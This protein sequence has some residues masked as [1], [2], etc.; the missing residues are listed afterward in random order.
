MLPL[1]ARWIIESPMFHVTLPA[2]HHRAADARL[3]AFSI[4]SRIA[5][6]KVQVHIGHDQV[7]SDAV[8]AQLSIGLFKRKRV[9]RR[10]FLAVEKPFVH[11]PEMRGF[12]V[13]PEVI[14]QASD[15]RQLLRRADWTTDPYWVINRRL[16]PGGDIFKGFGQVKLFEGVVHHDFEAW[17]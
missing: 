4:S 13:Q 2:L 1:T 9:R 6:R 12:D 5:L 15:Q 10:R 3:P 17:P 8:E 7:F 16:F 11:P 14:H